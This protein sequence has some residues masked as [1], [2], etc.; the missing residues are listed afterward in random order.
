MKM[1]KTIYFLFHWFVKIT[2]FLPQL[3]IFRMK[4]YYEDRSIQGRHIRSKAIVISNHNYIYDFGV[5]L[6]LFPTRTLRCAVAEIL[7]QKNIFMTALLKLFGCIRVDRNRLDFSFLDQMNRILDRG[8]VVEIFPESRL[9][10]AGEERPLEFK[11]SY[12]YLAL[13]SGA[14][15]IPVYSNGKLFEREKL[16]VIIGKPID[17]MALYDE[18]LPERENIKIINSYIRGKIIELKEKLDEQ[19]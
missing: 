5:M 4:V 8:G 14:P 9:P 11:P 17:V 10:D 15:V 19:S 16:K 18:E 1:R 7:Y 2:G 3:F 13:R 6:F 12:V